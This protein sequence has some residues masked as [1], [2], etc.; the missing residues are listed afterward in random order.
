MIALQILCGVLWMAFLVVACMYH[1]AID[2]KKF[3]ERKIV[4]LEEDNMFLRNNWT[5]RKSARPV[6]TYDEEY[7]DYENH[8][9]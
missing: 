5:P 3:L 4:R 7:D 6:A 1:L 8:P 2:D 9:Y